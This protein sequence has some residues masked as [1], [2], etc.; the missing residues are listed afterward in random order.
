[1]AVRHDDEPDEA[2]GSRIERGH[3]QGRTG[4]E[5]L[6][7]EEVD[8]VALVIGWDIGDGGD[9]G[10]DEAGLVLNGTQ[11]TRNAPI[12]PGGGDDAELERRHISL[13]AAVGRWRP[14]R[15]TAR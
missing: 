6:G 4:E 11:K 7:D 1:M 2:S 12:G 10:A 13:A 14:R 5:L 9:V 15:A 8:L 3:G